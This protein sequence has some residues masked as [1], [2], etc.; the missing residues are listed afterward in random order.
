LKS[1]SVIS[2]A[3]KGSFLICSSDSK[4]VNVMTR[5]HWSECVVTQPS[6]PL[7]SVALVDRRCK[8]GKSHGKFAGRHR[9]PSAYGVRSRAPAGGD[10]R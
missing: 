6:N 1:A 5:P 2:T 9:R 8:D 7:A 3:A 10:V 4:L